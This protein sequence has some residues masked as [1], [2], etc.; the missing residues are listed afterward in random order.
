LRALLS[1]L[2]RIEVIWEAASSREAVV[3]A[4]AC[5]PD[6]VLVDLQMPARDGLEA[7]SNIKKRWPQV[8]VV[9]LTLYRGDEGRIMAAGADG[10]L[11]KGCA[12]EE[13]LV[14]I[15]PTLHSAIAPDPPQ[16]CGLWKAALSGQTV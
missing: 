15:S 13:L 3:C 6:V 9:A 16:A 5:Q 4:G 8:R 12:T 1:T 11:V 2:P 10:F 14:A 7:I